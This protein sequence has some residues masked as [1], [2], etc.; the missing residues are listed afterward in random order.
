[1][2]EAGALEPA[3]WTVGD[4]KVGRDSVAF[5]SAAGGFRGGVDGA[6]D[7]DERMSAAPEREDVSMTLDQF[8]TVHRESCCT[9]CM[10]HPY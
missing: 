4:E 10:S 6:V 8:Q 9:A 5:P 2:L 7:V 3:S 1:M